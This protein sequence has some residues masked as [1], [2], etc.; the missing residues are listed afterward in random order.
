M[1]TIKPIL[2]KVVVKVKQA[3]EDTV[4]GIII[5]GTSKDKPLTAT[6][7]ARGPGG[8]IDSREVKMYVNP[9]DEV[10]IPSHAGTEFTFN[11]EDLLI[12]R[13]SDILA[14]IS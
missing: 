12:V 11:G 10:L 6:V 7:I 2:D 3:E 13:Q 4:N 9:G 14:M 1:T 5:A 8:L